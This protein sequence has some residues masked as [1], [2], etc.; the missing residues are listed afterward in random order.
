LVNTTETFGLD[1]I[2]DNKSV[3]G[4]FWVVC[5]IAATAHAGQVDKAGKPYIKHPIAVASYCN[6]DL[7]RCVAM[8]HDVLEDTFVTV[9]YLEEIGIG[10][11]II[12]P[13]LLLTRNKRETRMENATRVKS[14]KV[15]T[16]VKLADLKHNMDLSRIPN[17]T[18]KDFKRL[19]EYKMVKEYL[20]KG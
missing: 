12:Q 4:R 10:Q 16:A 8:L 17:P 11:D 18:E 9:E 1:M 3:A 13:L 2:R 20:E 14:C 6:T 19:E 5:K 7:E 15:A